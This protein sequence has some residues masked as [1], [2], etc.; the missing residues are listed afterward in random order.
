[1]NVWI[2][3]PS[4]F[5]SQRS[6]TVSE[7][8]LRLVRVS[9]EASLGLM[10]C[11]ICPQTARFARPPPDHPR[12]RN[13]SCLHTRNTRS[14]RSPNKPKIRQKK[15]ITI[16]SNS[17]RIPGRKWLNRPDSLRRPG[18][19]VTPRNTARFTEISSQLNWQKN[20]KNCIPVKSL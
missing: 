13:P 12:R 3:L 15:F 4:P 9:L 1:M 16:T 7:C 2:S 17:K 20:C 11:C 5:G 18:F 6:A 19:G 8:A 10:L 14:E